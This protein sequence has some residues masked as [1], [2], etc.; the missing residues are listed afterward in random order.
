MLVS[1]FSLPD[2][3]SPLQRFCDRIPTPAANIAIYVA[4]LLQGLPIIGSE[5]GGQ[6][7][8]CLRLT[9]R[10]GTKMTRIVITSWFQANMDNWI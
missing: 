6:Y 8:N 5:N 10:F 2:I 9:A 4:A 3:G 7:R 1:E